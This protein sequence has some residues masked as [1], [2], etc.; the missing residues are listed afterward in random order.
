MVVEPRQ[1]VRDGQ[2][3]QHLVAA[4]Q[5]FVRVHQVF[6]GAVRPLHDLSRD[7][8]REQTEADHDPQV[9]RRDAT[10]HRDDRREGGVVRLLHHQAPAEVGQ[11][12]GAAY[13]VLA[14]VIDVVVDPRP[15]ARLLRDRPLVVAPPRALRMGHD[16]AVFAHQ[17]DA[18]VGLG[19][20]DLKKAF[21]R[22]GID[23]RVE[24]ADRF[25][26]AHDGRGDELEARSALAKEVARAGSARLRKPLEHRFPDVGTFPGKDSHPTRRVQHEECSV[27]R[28]ALAHVGQVLSGFLLRDT[29]VPRAGGHAVGHR[30]ALRKRG[31]VEIA[32][33]VP[34]VQTLG[35][36]DQDLGDAL[37]ELQPEEFL[38]GPGGGVGHREG[39]EEGDRE[40]RRDDA[41]RQ[42]REGPPRHAHQG[43]AEHACP[44][45]AATSLNRRHRRDPPLGHR[46]TEALA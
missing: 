23:H 41:G 6:V 43:I 4:A 2:L 26:T 1:A 42:T 11:S 40:H 46:C 45:R 28:E 44:A 39:G 3:L 20:V 22:V 5:L 38:G 21:D 29:I 34:A 13:D 19:V 36:A 14:L 18:R 9:D 15:R 10:P 25:A 33:G 37:V 35:D 31:D 17:E 7:H 27:L 8:E 30:L 16:L 24:R 12:H 32:L